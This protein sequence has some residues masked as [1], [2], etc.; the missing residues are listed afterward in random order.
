[1]AERFCKLVFS[2]KTAALCMFTDASLTGHAL[3][4]TQVRRWQ[5]DVPIEEQQHDLLVCRGGIFKWAQRNW[6]I[7]EKYPIVKACADLDYMLVREGGFH[8]YCDHSNMVKLFSPDHEVK[9]HARGKLQRWALTLVG[10]R[11]VI[12]HIAG[13]NNL[14]VDILSRWGQPADATAGTT[15]AV[16]RVTIR[17]ALR[18][19]R[20][21]TG[22]T[23]W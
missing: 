17:S 8:G 6:S 18:K 7:V 20:T 19:L 21:S 1:M 3:V 15:L 5:D 12:H 22:E 16:K 9:Q 13:E 14:W 10:Y 4:S 11:Y 2:D 23:H